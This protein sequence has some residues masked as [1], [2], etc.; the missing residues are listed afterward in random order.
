MAA[1]GTKNVGVIYKGK[2]N[3]WPDGLVKW[4]PPEIAKGL[5]DGGD[6]Q[7]GYA[8]DSAKP[9]PTPK[10]PAAAPAKP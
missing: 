1:K 9:P 5:V 7:Y 4:F 10:I 3:L 6:G 8:P 2:D